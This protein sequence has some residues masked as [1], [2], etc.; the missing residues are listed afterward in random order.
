MSSKNNKKKKKSQA[1]KTSAQAQKPK[2]ATEEVDE[3]NIPVQ[4]LSEMLAFAHEAEADLD[5]AEENEIDIIVPTKKPEEKAEAKPQQPKT[6]VKPAEAPKAEAKPQQPKTEAKPAE[7]PKAEAKPQQPKTEA[8]PAEAPKAEEP[9]TE[10]KPVSG[11]PVSAEEAARQA[12]S[13][14]ALDRDLE[15]ARRQKLKEE[16]YLKHQREMELKKE[17]ERLAKAEQAKQRQISAMEAAKKREETKAAEEAHQKAEAPAA[18]PAPAKSTKKKNA[19]ARYFNRT[20]MSMNAAKGLAVAL[21]VVLLAYGGAFIYVNS[22]NE[23]IYSDLEKKLTGQSRLVSDSSI[24]YEMP[25]TSPLSAEEK[26]SLGLNEG[27][28]DS[29]CDGLTDYYEINVSKTDPANPDSDGDGLLDGREIR[30]G[31]DPL[32]PTSDGSTPDNEVIRDNTVAA[33]Q[34][35]AEIKGQLKTA[36]ATVSKVNNNSIQGTPGLVGYAYEF[37]TDK[38][39]DSCTLTFSYTDNQAENKNVNESNLSIFRFNADKLSF[40]QLTSAVNAD[41]NTVSAEITENGIYALCD[42]SILS[43]KGSTNV[44][45]LIDNSGSMYPEELCANSEENDVEFKRLDFAVNLID[46]LG[47]EANYGAG[48]FSGGYANIT[49]ISNDVNTVKQK[50]SDIRNKNQVFSGTEIAGA[51]TNA[52]KEFGGI[53]SADRNY[54]ILLTD[55]M[56]SVANAAKD[57]A[58]ID[59]AKAANITIFTIGLGK[60]IDAEYLYSIAEQTNG[61]FFQASNADALENIY[62]KIQSFMSYNQV[63]FEEES[64]TK[65]YIVADSGFNV[66]KDGIGYNNFRSDFAPNGADVGIAGLIRDYYNGSLEMS[67][68]GYTTDD[69]T[70]VPGYDIS[71]ISGIT[72]GK[73][74]LNSVELGALASYNEYI[75]RSDKWNYRSIK[76]GTLHYTSDT[77][78]FIDEANLKVIT[79]HYDYSAPEQSGFMKFLR[80]ITFNKIKD[81]T[82]YECVLIDSKNLQGDDLAIMNM[83]RWYCAIPDAADKCNILDF[84]YNGDEAFDELINELTTG[85]PA[86]I[87][88]GSSAMN[89]IRIIRDEENPDLFVIDAYD[90]NSPERSTRITL[91]RTPVYDGDTIPTYQYSASRGS[92]TE[93]LRIIVEK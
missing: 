52:V 84:G 90:S 36:Y 72:D 16:A 47:V 83:L 73:A 30:A 14:D 71:S 39:F 50:I 33:E 55:G 44:F 9:K 5:K 81:F 20:L 88:Y 74:D 85:T 93:P 53:S 48:E 43:E 67:R 11:P 46:M 31:L 54:I 87:T 65:G 6:E 60:Y 24:Q 2:A 27:L 61:Q 45:F 78:A 82:D 8:K 49:P 58:A 19:T 42:T 77:R 3:K 12:A 92:V 56:P 10:T 29:D 91:R 63:T 25:D 7:A 15:N 64:G 41:A 17:E 40:D 89:A 62:E 51:I 34:V 59:A 66:L 22:K 35:R 18:A 28:E 69:G 70:S 32:N 38:N 80:T 4:S 26:T 86:L 37:Y 79:S 21:V 76:G 13:E 75:Q 1:P 57:K 68:E 23:E